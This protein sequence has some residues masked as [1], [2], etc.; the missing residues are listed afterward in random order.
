ME[1]GGRQTDPFSL[2]TSDRMKLVAQNVE[3]S[4]NDFKVLSWC[5][6]SIPGM[7]E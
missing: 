2:P 1:R 5:E 4:V 6:M 7:E 3:N